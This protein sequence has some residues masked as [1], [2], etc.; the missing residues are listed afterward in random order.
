M[1]RP[2]PHNAAGH[3][4]AMIVD[5]PG[6]LDNVAI[7]RALWGNPWSL[8]F[9]PDTPRRER[10]AQ[11]RRRLAHDKANAKR[12][13]VLLGRVSE[14]RCLIPATHIRLS[15]DA[16]HSLAQGA[17]VRQLLGIRASV[18]VVR[19]VRTR[20]AVLVDVADYCRPVV[21]IRPTV[22]ERIVGWLVEAPRTP[23]ELAVLLGRS[24]YQ[25]ARDG[26]W[27]PAELS[28]ADKRVLVELREGGVVA[29][30]GDRWP[31][32]RGVEVVGKWREGVDAL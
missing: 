13:A 10:D 11:Y 28:G 6:E 5:C 16:A 15:L 24:P 31:S 29:L 2:T 19:E 17:T 3:A 27:V 1:I 25:R 9:E 12:A 21:E 18:P 20:S 26:R 23:G 7:G 30:V 4:L 32:A 22:R 8:R 14:A